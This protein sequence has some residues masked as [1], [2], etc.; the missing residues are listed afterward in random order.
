LGIGAAGGGKSSGYEG[1]MLATRLEELRK[2]RS[3]RAPEIKKKEVTNN[4]FG[5]TPQG[6]PPATIPRKSSRK[7]KRKK[8]AKR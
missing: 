2:E 7:N 1:A 3:A 4:S 8:K 6:T 5:S